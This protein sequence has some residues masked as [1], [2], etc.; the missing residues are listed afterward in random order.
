MTDRWD[1][2]TFDTYAELAQVAAD[3]H[4]WCR[5][6]MFGAVVPPQVLMG[7][8]EQLRLERAEVRSLDALVVRNTKREGA[9]RAA[10]LD[11][12][13]LRFCPKCDAVTS[14]YE[15]ID[16]YFCDGCGTEWDE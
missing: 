15:R 10:I 3:N 5:E 6:G 13:D 7:L 12:T 8:L 9:L 2:D 11:L 16:G 14:P 1:D 4:G